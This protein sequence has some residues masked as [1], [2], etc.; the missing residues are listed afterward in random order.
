[1]HVS[2]PPARLRPTSAPAVAGQPANDTGPQRPAPAPAAPEEARLFADGAGQRARRLGDAHRAAPALLQLLRNEPLD[3]TAAVAP[4]P[5]IQSAGAAR[6]SAVSRAFDAV[7]A[8]AVKAGLRY[9]D[10]NTEAWA[11][12]WHVLNGGHGVDA[13]YFIFN[14]D[15]FGMSLLG[16]MLDKARRGEPVRLMVDASGD[17]GGRL[18]F[19]LTGKGQDYLQELVNTGNG[20]VKVYHP[21]HK[22]FLK[23]LSL[24]PRPFAGVASNH[25]KLIR[26]ADWAMTGGRNISKDYFTSPADHGAGFRDSDVLVEG[27]DASAQLG[28]AFD[29]E[30]DRKDHFTV[31]PDTFGNWVKRDIE[32]LGAHAMMDAWMKAAPLD[33][34]VTKALREDP[35]T[36]EGMAAEL[37]ARALAELPA[38]GLDREASKREIKS[39]HKL[40][41][42][43]AGY[44]DLRGAARDF[45]PRA[46]QRQVDM[47]ALDRTSAAVDGKDN[48]NQGLQS[49]L[50]GAQKRVVIQN[51]YVVLTQNAIAALKAAGERGVKIDLMTNSPESTDS[52]L[53]QA[54][55]LEDWPRLLAD[56]PN[57]RI[58]VLTG[59]QKLHA[60][61]AVADDEVALVGSYNLD[62][63]SARINGEIAALSRSP[64][65]ARDVRR[66]FERDM[67][68]PRFAV[69]EYTIK[70]NADGS[71]QRDA[72]GR[73]IVDFGPEDHV[74]LGKRIMYR[75]LRWLANL[76]R[77]IPALAP[78]RRD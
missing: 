71:A 31:Y 22:K 19:T 21:L 15:V 14:R 33:A 47:K 55:F 51:P 5:A 60:K 69:K 40:A 38:R 7:P 53:T 9:L 35:A 11:G 29:R 28:R 30:F 6:P 67:A 77:Y 48:L 12:L 1:M 24:D 70:R 25:D 4:A 43:L 45:D 8:T 17:F 49:I 68:D 20:Q 76:A 75:G 16:G 34:R 32:L 42:E 18:G 52:A 63:I 27:Q 13:T 65:L 58:H 36:R 74:G 64:E 73:P 46:R 44:P 26:N 57:L 50:A 23:A 39:L 62:L 2:K 72:K 37:V 54:F 61:V 10:K 41:N 56:I 66:G 3:A 78:L 59:E